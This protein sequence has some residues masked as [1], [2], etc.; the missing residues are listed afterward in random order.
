MR[1]FTVSQQS[2]DGRGNRARVV[3]N[4]GIV[5]IERVEK[6]LAP[7]Q[8]RA[9]IELAKA[10]YDFL[11]GSGHSSWK[12]HITFASVAAEC[13]VGKYWQAGSKTQAITNLLAMTYEYSSGNF[14][15]T[16]ISIVN[17]GILYREKKHNPV[18]RGEVEAI[19]NLILILE[20]KFP[21]L[22]DKDFLNSL[23]TQ[24]K[25]S[26]EAPS[27]PKQKIYQHEMFKERFHELLREMNKQEAGLRFENFL[28]D[29]FAHFDLDPKGSFSVVGEQI[30]GSFVLDH[31]TYLVEAKWHKNSIQEK[32]LLIFR[33]KIEGK[34][35]ITRGVFIALNGYTDGAMQAICTGKQPNF[36]LV[37]GQDIYNLLCNK[38]DFAELLRF[39]RRS[40]A[41][42]KIFARYECLP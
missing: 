28:Y 12:G 26:T 30:D 15:R 41:E 34:S 7:K 32:D 31:D 10:F 29:L 17:N 2:A 20:R 24:V 14:E 38:W 22:W 25:A 16:I 9:I 36:F 13:G 3:V 37:D 18:T 33:G 42:G 23:P 21:M 35:S 4:Q 19:N 40:M 39:K 8:H 6:M 5:L 11:P 1:D 27:G